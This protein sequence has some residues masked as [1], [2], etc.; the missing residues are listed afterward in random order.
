MQKNKVLHTYLLEYARE[1]QAVVTG[2]SPC[3]SRSRSDEAK[4][5]ENVHSNE[6]RC[7]SRRA[8]FRLCSIVEDLY[9][10]KA[11]WSAQSFFNIA[12]AEEDDDVGGKSKRPVDEDRKEHC[13]RYID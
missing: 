11:V 2:K 1:G 9:E 3:L 12:E 4:R 8:P 5:G 7:H 6:D 10:W 13:S